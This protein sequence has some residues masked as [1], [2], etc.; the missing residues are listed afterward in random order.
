MKYYRAARFQRVART[1]ELWICGSESISFALNRVKYA[2]ETRHI[3]ISRQST[4]RALHL[5]EIGGTILQ[6]HTR[7]MNSTTDPVPVGHRVDISWPDAPW[8]QH[9]YRHVE[10]AKLDIF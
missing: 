6:I 2:G 3:G 4:T 7:Q 1:A 8:F 9:F 10:V 5:V